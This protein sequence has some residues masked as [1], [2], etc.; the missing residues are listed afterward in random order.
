MQF[1]LD[2]VERGL[3]LFELS[4]DPNL[5]HDGNAIHDAFTKKLVTKE[6]KEIVNELIQTRSILLLQ[7]IQN[8]S[9]IGSEPNYPKMDISFECKFCKGV[10][11]IPH[12]EVV[13]IPNCKQCDSCYGTGIKTEMCAA[14]AGTGKKGRDICGLCRG[15][16][17]YKFKKNKARKETIVC[18][19]CGGSKYIGCFKTT[20]KIIAAQICVICSGKGQIK[21]VK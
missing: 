14:C 21:I 13:Y 17:R 16:G 4:I 11:A 19:K 8:R 9:E 7:A 10:G 18:P 20:G 6:G 15:S 12:M 5:I 2:V 3:R 1:S